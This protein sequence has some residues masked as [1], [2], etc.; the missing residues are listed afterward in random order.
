ML[1]L[2]ATALY[3]L[4]R[5]GRLLLTDPVRLRRQ[6]RRRRIPA[7]VTSEGLRLPRTWVDAASGREASDAEALAVYWLERLAP[8]DAGAGRAS[9][10]RRYLPPTDLLSP[11]EAARRLRADLAFL[12]RLDAEAVLPSLLVDG[13]IR[14]DAAL[15]DLVAREDEDDALRD[16]ADARRAE[17]LDWGRFAWVED[18]DVGAALPP[19]ATKEAPKQALDA[20]PHAW[21]IPKGLTEDEEPEGRR[22]LIETEGY[23][24]VE[25]DD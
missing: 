20:A 19:A 16:A 15:V 6:A 18:L 11:P 7:L 10:D 12:V 4:P 1:P 3:D 5:A 23:E 13:E 25:E 2:D 21:R 14:Y 22:R 9:R 8:A 24:T 17:V